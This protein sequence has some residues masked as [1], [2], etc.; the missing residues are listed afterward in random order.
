MTAAVSPGPVLIRGD[1]SAP[2]LSIA[3]HL[4]AVDNRVQRP[5]PGYECSLWSRIGGRYPV[6]DGFVDRNTALAMLVAGE[7]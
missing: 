6:F 5:Q 7:A 3:P 4:R 1:R 2:R